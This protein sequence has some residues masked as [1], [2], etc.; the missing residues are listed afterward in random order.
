MKIKL[1][2][3]LSIMIAVFILIPSAF[4]A[5]Q[6]ANKTDSLSEIDNDILGTSDYYFDASAL[7][8]GSG[9]ISNPYKILNYSRINSDSVR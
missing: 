4:A 3:L 6:S 1:L 9:S 2:I 8:D 5:D 7:N